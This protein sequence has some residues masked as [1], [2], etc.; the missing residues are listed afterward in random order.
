MLRAKLQADVSVRHKNE[1]AFIDRFTGIFQ[2]DERKSLKFFSCVGDRSISKNETFLVF[3]Q[4]VDFLSRKR[5]DIEHKGT[6]RYELEV[7][8]DSP[9]IES[10]VPNFDCKWDLSKNDKDKR[11]RFVLQRLLSYVAKLIL[12][13]RL[14]QNCT[15]IANL[16]KNIKLSFK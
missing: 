13:I 14:K 15:A 2:R 5:S 12:M 4:R 11:K 3:D 6:K 10:I 16:V 7:N 1:L 9:I 8:K